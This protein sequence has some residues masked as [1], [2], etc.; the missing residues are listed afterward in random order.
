[1]KK[2]TPQYYVSALKDF[3]LMR[4][5]VSSVGFAGVLFFLLTLTV[6][7][8]ST[9]ESWVVITIGYGLIGMLMLAA[10]TIYSSN[11]A[12]NDLQIQKALL[13][14]RRKKLHLQRKSRSL[15]QRIQR[16]DYGFQ[17][18]SLQESTQ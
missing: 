6:V 7:R 10:Y 3:A 1:M 13:V 11:Y 15:K 12:T 14:L 4:L 16:E 18:S 8:G 2:Q 17:T 9:L 5:F